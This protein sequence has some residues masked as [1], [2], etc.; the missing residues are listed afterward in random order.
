MKGLKRLRHTWPKQGP[1]ERRL[2]PRLQARFPLVVD[3]GERVASLSCWVNNISLDG[4]SFTSPDFFDIFTKVDVSFE[5]PLADRDGTLIMHVF[6]VPATIV[7]CE[8][9]E[10]DDAREEYEVALRF[11]NAS[12]E[13]DRVLSVFSLQMHLYD[14]DSTIS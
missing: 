4:I 1:A 3:P 7:R 6:N 2:Y 9:D 13:R 10:P 12:E 5:V 8:P 11:N 14:P